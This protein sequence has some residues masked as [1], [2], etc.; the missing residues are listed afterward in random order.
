[1]ESSSRCTRILIAHCRT[2]HSLCIPI[3]SGRSS[4]N[5]VLAPSRLAV[6]LLPLH[7]E[8]KARSP[9]EFFRQERLIEW[10]VSIDMRIISGF[11]I[12]A[13]LAGSARAQSPEAVMDRA[14]KNYESMKSL[15]AEFTQ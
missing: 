9:T 14:V 7:R 2:G 11:A 1:M 3:N 12:V 13:V 15:R 4:R 5:C 6:E 10:W 8:R